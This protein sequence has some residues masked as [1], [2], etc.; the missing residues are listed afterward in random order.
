MNIR[1]K[2]RLLAEV[3]I[4]ALIVIFVPMLFKKNNESKMTNIA[5]FPS[6]PAQPNTSQMTPAVT[7]EN[8]QEQPVS[9]QPAMPVAA[10]AVTAPVATAMVDTSL[11]PPANN[12]SEVPNS[13]SP[14]QE[15]NM[16]SVP[17]Q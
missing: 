4:L 2:L 5:S 8:N 13:A 7:Q 14:S 17:S 1:F 12:A 6:A 3:V 11:T 10:P 9:P 16:Q 15:E